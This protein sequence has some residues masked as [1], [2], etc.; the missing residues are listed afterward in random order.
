MEEKMLMLRNFAA[1]ERDVKLIHYFLC[2]LKT[3]ALLEM[4]KTTAHPLMK[5]TALQ[6][7]GNFNDF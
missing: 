2:F 5:T 1:K 3:P 7:V 6:T 4:Y